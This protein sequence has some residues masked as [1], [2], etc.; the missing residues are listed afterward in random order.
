MKASLKYIPKYDPEF[1]PAILEIQKFNEE[2]S[3][4]PDKTELIIC[5]ERTKGH[6]YHYIKRELDMMMKIIL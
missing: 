6:N 3:K 1:K 5:L 4:S 2:V